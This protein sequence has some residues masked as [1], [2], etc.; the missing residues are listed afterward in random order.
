MKLSTFRPPNQSDFPQMPAGVEEPLKVTSKQVT[1]ITT[2]LQGAISIADNLDA[3][4]IEVDI[5]HNKSFNVSLQKLKSRPLG[6]SCIY[7]KG[8]F[9]IA[10]LELLAEKK[11]SLRV[12]L[13]SENTGSFPARIIVWGGGQ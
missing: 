8:Q 2:A 9:G 4:L 10:Q 13:I 3:E 5:E 7:V 6:A 12:W 11:V 1:D